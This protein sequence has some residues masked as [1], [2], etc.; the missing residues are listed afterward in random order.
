MPEAHDAAATHDSAE[1]ASPLQRSAHDEAATADSAMAE[2]VEEWNERWTEDRRERARRVLAHMR[3]RFPD[4]PRCPFCH[5]TEFTVTD[6]VVLFPEATG[7]L[8]GVGFPVFQ[9]ICTVCGYTQLFNRPIAFASPTEPVRPE[10]PERPED[11][12][13]PEEEVLAP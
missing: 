13:E 5:Q 10:R 8:G 7:P 12:G 6:E 1:R 2:E 9:L 3:Q 11:P 4:A